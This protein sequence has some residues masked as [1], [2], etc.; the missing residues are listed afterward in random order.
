MRQLKELLSNDI[1][2]LKLYGGS[3]VLSE[4][5][6]DYKNWNVHEFIGI[7]SSDVETKTKLTYLKR[8]LTLRLIKGEEMIKLDFEN[9]TLD[10]FEINYY[11]ILNDAKEETTLRVDVVDEEKLKGIIFNFFRKTKIDVL[12]VPITRTFDTM[13]EVLYSKRVKCEL[14]NSFLKLRSLNEDLTLKKYFDDKMTLTEVATVSVEKKGKSKDFR[15]DYRYKVHI[16]Y[17]DNLELYLGVDANTIYYKEGVGNS[18]RNLR[19]T[20]LLPYRMENEGLIKA[21]LNQIRTVPSIENVLEM[22][23]ML[24]QLWL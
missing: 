19:T 6:K 4:L 23:R 11:D 8:K 5:L 21:L 18:I 14:D 10:S 24:T 3:S 12:K 13:M 17:T 20:F 16:L 9:E 22:K 2:L 7:E 1:L 15:V